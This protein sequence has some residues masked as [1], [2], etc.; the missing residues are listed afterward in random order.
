MIERGG[1]GK[2]DEIVGDKRSHV[3]TPHCGEEISNVSFNGHLATP[4]SKDARPILRLS[5]ILSVNKPRPRSRSNLGPSN[6]AEWT[7]PPY[8][9]SLDPSR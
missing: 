1:V 2:I 7:N 4:D 8:T 3:W 6:S 9:P 5:R